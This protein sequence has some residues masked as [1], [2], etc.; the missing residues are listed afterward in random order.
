MDAGY[1]VSSD[2]EESEEDEEDDDEELQLDQA[3]AGVRDEGMQIHNLVC[4]LWTP[5]VPHCT[6]AGYIV[7]HSRLATPLPCSHT[8]QI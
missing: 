3:A 8:G 2:E 6:C 4:R 1:D 7:Y 5:C